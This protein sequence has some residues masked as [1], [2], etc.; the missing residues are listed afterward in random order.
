VSGDRK[1][2]PFFDFD[3]RHRLMREVERGVLMPL[4]AEEQAARMKLTRG[5]SAGGTLPPLE[6]LPDSSRSDPESEAFWTALMAIAWI[7]FR[8]IEQVA[9]FSPR[10]WA[11]CQRWVG[12]TLTPMSPPTLDDLEDRLYQFGMDTNAAMDAR[13]SLF[14]RL[15]QK[16]RISA[17]GI[18]SGKVVKLSRDNWYFIKLAG[19]AARLWEKP[20]VT[21]VLVPRKAVLRNWKSS[22]KSGK[23]VFK[24]DPMRARSARQIYRRLN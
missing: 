8:D 20:V 23:F 18:V 16:G 24:I 21:D 5:S 2:N 19:L 10:A 15:M 3:E 12:R 14:M 11:D 4:E 1:D 17:T 6:T 9:F 22:G 7:A 13:Y